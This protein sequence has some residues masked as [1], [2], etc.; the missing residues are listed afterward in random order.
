MCP[1]LLANRTTRRKCLRQ[2]SESIKHGRVHY[3]EFMFEKKKF[4]PAVQMSLSIRNRKFGAFNIDCLVAPFIFRAQP[5]TCSVYR[6]EEKDSCSR[7]HTL[8]YS[9]TSPNSPP[10]VPA[11]PGQQ[12][13][14]VM[15]VSNQQHRPCTTKRVRLNNT[16]PYFFYIYRTGVHSINSLPCWR[17]IKVSFLTWQ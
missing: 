12:T 7:C 13:M 10:S 1:K 6:K 17:R 11:G 2:V 3:M 15:P 9:I 5:T 8:R 16:I 14:R 4:Q